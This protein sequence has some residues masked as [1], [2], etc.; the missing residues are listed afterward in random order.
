[1]SY[2]DGKAGL[3]DATTYYW[4]VQAVD[5]YG[6]ITDSSEV[7]SFKTNNTNGIPGIITGIVYSDLNSAFIAAATVTV[8]LAN[9]VYT[10]TS[11][12]NGSYVIA[13]NGSG[14]ASVQAS[15]SDTQGDLISDVSVNA[16]T[17]TVMNAVVNPDVI[18]KGDLNANGT[19]TLADAILALQV[20]SGKSPALHKAADVNG[21]GKIGLPEIIYILQKAAGLR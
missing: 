2:V 14:I 5:S 8:T 18:D 1:M 7:W 9:Q 3:L 19:V 11:A 12:A 13:V 6:V 16:G 20:I 15:T 10:A 4:K 21:D 17:A